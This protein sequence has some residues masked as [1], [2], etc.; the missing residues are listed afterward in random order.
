MHAGSKRSSAPG[1]VGIN[2]RI[3]GS[4]HEAE[5]FLYSNIVREMDE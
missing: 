1:N 4:V 2:Q 5:N 3:Q